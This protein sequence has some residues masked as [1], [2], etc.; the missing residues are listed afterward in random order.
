VSARIQQEKQ[1]AAIKAHQAEMRRKRDSS[2]RRDVH[3]SSSPGQQKSSDQVKSP[4]HEESERIA[5]MLDFVFTVL[6]FK[7]KEICPCT[8]QK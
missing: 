5:F 2:Q 6:I 3:C 7:K 1:L 8:I 4:S